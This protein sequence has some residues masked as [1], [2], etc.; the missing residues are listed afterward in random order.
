MRRNPTKPDR[1]RHTLSIEQ[2]NAIDLLVTGQSDREVAAAVGVTRQTV[3]GWRLY[4]PYF[5]AELNRRRDAI[6]GA[7]GAKF[8]NLLVRAIDRID[9]ELEGEHGWR[10]ALEIIKLGRPRAGEVG[11]TDPLEIIDAEA[12]RRR[13]DSLEDLMSPP[14]SEAERAAVLEDLLARVRELDGQE[15]AGPGAEATEQGDPKLGG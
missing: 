10:V 11:P 13:R 3:C 7:A 15:T 14:A 4:D 5:Q 9:Q 2:L 12:R 6:W 1:I 8:Q